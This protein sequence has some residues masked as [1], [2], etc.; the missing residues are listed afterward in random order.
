MTE[1]RLGHE[2][3]ARMPPTIRR[4]REAGGQRVYVSALVPRSYSFHQENDLCDVQ[5]LRVLHC[6]W[7][8]HGDMSFSPPHVPYSRAI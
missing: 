8:S 7:S 4:T 2:S 1:T 3:R 6:E 5:C